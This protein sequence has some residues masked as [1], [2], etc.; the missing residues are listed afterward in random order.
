MNKVIELYRGTDIES[1]KRFLNGDINKISWWSHDFE[2]I[3]H[4]Y[5]GCVIK[6]TIELIDYDKVNIFGLDY[7]SNYDDLDAEDIDDYEYACQYIFYHK[8]LESRKRIEEKLMKKGVNRDT[9]Q[10]A[11]LDSYNSEEEVMEIEMEQAKK[12]LVKKKY[13]SENVDWKEK[14]KIYAFLVRK[15]ISS[16]VIKKVMELQDV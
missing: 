5:E 13:E 15:G 1:G 11:F 8:E 2:T 14:Q 3:E 10:K 9:I 4:Y 7:I 12:L 16:T 6:M